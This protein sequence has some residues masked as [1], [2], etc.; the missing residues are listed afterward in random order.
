MKWIQSKL[1]VSVWHRVS[2]TEYN[3]VASQRRTYQTFTLP[4]CLCRLFR[5]WSKQTEG[6]LL[7]NHLNMR[8]MEHITEI[9]QEAERGGAVD[10]HM[11]WELSVRAVG[12]V[13]REKLVGGQT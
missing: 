2:D 8:G 12:L 13:T 6:K 1:A 3:N 9:V 5:A 4:G 10:T 7:V 11:A